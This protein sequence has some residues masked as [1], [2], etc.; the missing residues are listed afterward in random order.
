MSM[1]LVV[2]EIKKQNISIT[3]YEQLDKEI[4][5]NIKKYD[6][7]VLTEDNKKEISA[8]KANLNKLAK[9]IDSERIA[10]TREY[11]E[12]LNTF[13]TQC[14]ALKQKVVTVSDKLNEQLKKDEER[15]KEEKKQR[16]IDF[17][18]NKV[19]D[20]SNL[21]KFENVFNERM[22][23]ATHSEETACDEIVEFIAKVK[24]DLKIIEDLK[25]YELLLK[26]YYLK[27]FDLSKTLQEKARLEGQKKA[28]EEQ[29]VK[30]SEV[31]QEINTNV[32]KR[33]IDANKEEQYHRTFEV[34]G[35][36]EQ[37][38]ALGNFMNSNNIK[39]NKIEE[40]K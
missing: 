34:W 24:G 22:L 4:S 17:Y 14:N 36:R 29:K 9:A 15:Q 30:T 3:N 25:E 31:V 26:D 2:S 28:I 8:V 5:E 20:L 21:V 32:V 38:I 33:Q 18:K 1:E 39:F 11:N 7:L 13:I 37:I 12:P 10:K 6:G 16:L 23:N 27:C 40:E 35:S 19:E